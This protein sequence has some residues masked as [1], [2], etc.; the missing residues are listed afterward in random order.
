MPTARLILQ[1]HDELIVECD[2]QDAEKC[3]TVLAEEMARSAALAVPL[4]A[5]AHSGENWLAAKG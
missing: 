2:A 3:C 5:D 1:V 4:N